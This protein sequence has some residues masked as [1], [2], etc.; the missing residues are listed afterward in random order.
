M[1]VLVIVSGDDMNAVK[2]ARRT[3][4]IL[5]MIFRPSSTHNSTGTMSTLK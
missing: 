1:V 4:M 2:I 3:R 5:Q